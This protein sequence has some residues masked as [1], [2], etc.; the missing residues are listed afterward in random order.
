M[1][2]EITGC[3]KTTDHGNRAVRRRFAAARLLGWRYRILL[4][5][6]MSVSGECRVLSD[7]DLCVGLIIPSEK[8]YGDGVASDCV[9]ET[10][11]MRRPRPTTAVELNIYIYIYIYMKTS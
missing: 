5:A 4:G 7:R 2:E 9:L 3:M 10:S 11:T 1:R 8:S 6:R